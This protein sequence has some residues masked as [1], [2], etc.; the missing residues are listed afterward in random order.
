MLGYFAWARLVKPC[1][2]PP[3]P[4]TSIKEVLIHDAF[5]NLLHCYF[6]NIY[7]SQGSNDPKLFQALD[8]QLYQALEQF[9]QV[10]DR[11][12]ESEKK[13]KSRAST[14]IQLAINLIQELD[15]ISPVGW[16]IEEQRMIVREAVGTEKKELEHQK[17]FDFY[18]EVERTEKLLN[19]VAERA[20]AVRERARIRRNT[21]ESKEYK[22][23]IDHHRVMQEIK[24]RTDE[25]EW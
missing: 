15:K 23:R 14:P 11:P 7:D 13:F 6:T 9:Y 21:L 25:L 3:R 24:Q 17:I 20:E 18:A 10:Y 1:R 2:P 4:Q 5:V 22:A 12:L 16:I 19:E 8:S